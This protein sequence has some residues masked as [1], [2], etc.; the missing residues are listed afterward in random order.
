M[1]KGE[2]YRFDFLKVF[3]DTMKA[4]RKH[5]CIYPNLVESLM[6]SKALESLLITMADIIYFANTELSYEELTDFIKEE[7]VMEEILYEVLFYVPGKTQ[8]KNRNKASRI[9]TRKAAYQL[10]FRILR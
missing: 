7:K 3:Q 5:W 2:Y 10:I 6:Q 8:S 4:L 1:E 9:E